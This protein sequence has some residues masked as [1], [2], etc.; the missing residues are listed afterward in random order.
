MPVGNSTLTIANVLCQREAT[1]VYDSTHSD[2]GHPPSSSPV[3]WQR[4][5]STGYVVDAVACMLKH[6]VSS[7]IVTQESKGVVGI[8]TERDI[9]FRTSCQAVLSSELKVAEI[10][11][12]RIMCIQPSATVMDALAS[13]S[14]KAFRHFAVLHESPLHL[15]DVDNHNNP[16]QAT[17]ASNENGPSDIVPEAAMRSVLTLKDILKALA[18]RG[19][20]RLGCTVLKTK[21]STLLKSKVA[22]TPLILNAR[23]EDEIYVSEAVAAMVTHRIGSV[24][25]LDEAH[26]VVGLFTENDYLS[27]VVEEK[28]DPTQVTF[29]SVCSSPVVCISPDSTLDELMTSIIDTQ[30]FGH[31]PVQCPKTGEIRGVLSIKDIAKELSKG[32]ETARGYW[33]LDYFRKLTTGATEPE[34]ATAVVT[35]SKIDVKTHED[36]V[37]PTK[38]KIIT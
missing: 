6:K 28:L 25:L 23:V 2:K 19:G 18:R 27:K 17:P 7:L 29:A 24:V 5:P 21:V 36:Q 3:S 30:N 20:H 9:L 38:K 13:M 32:H 1:A 8:L 26:H 16:T 35:D 4:I 37:L 14:K 10:M 31:F 22:A 12:E 11:T 15:P 33:L 34:P